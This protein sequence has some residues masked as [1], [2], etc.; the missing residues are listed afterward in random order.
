[1]RVGDPSHLF[2]FESEVSSGA[3][4]EDPAAGDEYWQIGSTVG[5]ACPGAADA[6]GV[7]DYDAVAFGCIFEAAEELVKALSTEAVAAKTKTRPNNVGCRQNR[8]Q[9]VT[10][11]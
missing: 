1:M 11:L 3:Q 8:F 6:D 7:V 5:L 9:T 10:Q 2:L 4:A